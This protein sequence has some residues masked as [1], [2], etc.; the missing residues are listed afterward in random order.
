MDG[1]IFKNSNCFE[2]RNFYFKTVQKL[3]SKF[4]MRSGRM[5]HV[6]L[7]SDTDVL[8]NEVSKKSFYTFEDIDLRES[9]VKLQKKNE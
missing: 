2:L 4:F 1:L 6:E 8:P 3:F 5:H 7:S 9:Y